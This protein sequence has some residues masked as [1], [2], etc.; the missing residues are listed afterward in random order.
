M[1]VLLLWKEADFEPG[2]GLDLQLQAM[3]EAVNLHSDPELIEL[4]VDN[5]EHEFKPETLYQ[6][7]LRRCTIA[8][9]PISEDAWEV[10]NVTELQH[11]GDGVWDEPMN[12]Y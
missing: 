6:L 2:D 1:I 12:A 3:T 7:Q 9:D 4:A 5:C 8:A 11:R 10:A